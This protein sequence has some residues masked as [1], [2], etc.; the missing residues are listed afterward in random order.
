[1]PPNF[2]INVIRGR[3]SVINIVY[4]GQ[5]MDIL[6]AI[7]PYKNIPDS[8]DLTK[9]ENKEIIKNNLNLMDKLINDMIEINEL[10]YNQSI[11]LL[12]GKKL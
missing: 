6:F 12:T 2:K 4:E 5:K 10:I 3:V 9:N 1:A 8:I 11:L 7:V